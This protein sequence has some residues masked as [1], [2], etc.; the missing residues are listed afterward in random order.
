MCYHD[1]PL[2]QDETVLALRQAVWLDNAQFVKDLNEQHAGHAT[3]KLNHLGD[4]T[5]E[6]Y[7]ASLSPISDDSI[8]KA[9]EDM[10]AVRR[11]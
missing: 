8:A 7:K 9:T 6:E 11:S 1:T 5:H 3:F 2:P 4:L 10:I